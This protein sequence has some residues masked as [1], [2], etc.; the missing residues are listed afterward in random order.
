MRTMLGG[1]C[2]HYDCTNRNSF[3]YCKTTAC[4][5]NNYM[6]EQ[7]EVWPTSNQSERIVFKPVTNA[8]RI[9]SISDEE[10]AYF[11]CDIGEC[12]RRCPAKIGDCIFSDSSCKDAWLEWLKSPTEDGHES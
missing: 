4:I 9:R 10:L 11:L 12:D 6:H 5:N 2:T 3:G 7:Y 1:P 8:D